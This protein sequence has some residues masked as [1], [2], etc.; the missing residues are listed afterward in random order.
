MCGI[1]GMVSFK[2][3]IRKK[4]GILAGMQNA[5]LRR[6]PDQEGMFV[7]EPQ[8]IMAHRR[9]AVIDVEHGRQPMTRSHNGET[10]TI[11]YNGELYNTDELRQE[12]MS[13]GAVFEDRKS[14]V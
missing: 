3:D 4:K 1:C 11:V 12:L 6:G 9:L 7:T 2:K 10:Y 5:L 8:C 14:T 13:L